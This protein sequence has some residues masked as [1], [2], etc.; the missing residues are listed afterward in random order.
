MSRLLKSIKS[1]NFEI[2][3]W[4]NEKDLEEGGIV[5]FQT[6]SLKKS[7][8]DNSGTFRDQRLIL[9]KQDLERVIVLLRKTQEFLL[10]EG[11]DGK[12]GDEH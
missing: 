7:W 4:E 10:L 6:V 11:E 9:R 1:G 12:K 5:A 3:V 8:R 2:S